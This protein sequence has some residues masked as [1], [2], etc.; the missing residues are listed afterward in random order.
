M[1]AF[2]RASIAPTPAMGMGP[3]DAFWL[4]EVNRWNFTFACDFR[5]YA[6]TDSDLFHE[7]WNVRYLRKCHMVGHGFAVSDSEWINI[8]D[9]IAASAND[10]EDDES[11]SDEEQPVAEV[12]E[13]AWVKLP[14]LLDQLYQDD[15]HHQLSLA[16]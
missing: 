4:E 3:S 9:T 11:A 2:A 12:E 6:F 7:S 1:A 13:P 8:H 15:V 14:W 16:F 5:S 10:S